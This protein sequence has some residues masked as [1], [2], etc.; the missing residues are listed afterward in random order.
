MSPSRFSTQKLSFKLIILVLLVSLLPLTAVS[1]INLLNIQ[2]KL[3]TAKRTELETLSQTLTQEVDAKL[4]SKK[5]FIESLARNPSTIRSTSDAN[6]HTESDLWASYDGSNYD[7]ETGMTNNKSLATWNAHNDIDP[8]YSIYLNDYCMTTGI[9]EILITDTRGFVFTNS[10]VIPSDFVQYEETWWT[11]CLQSQSGTYVDIGYFDDTNQVFLTIV[12]KV[13][14]FNGDF[15]GMVKARYNFGEITDYLHKILQGELISE[16]NGTTA[17][18]DCYSCHVQQDFNDNETTT[19]INQSAHISEDIDCTMCHGQ[20]SQ[21]GIGANITTS[22][23]NGPTMGSENVRVA[24]T[25]MSDGTILTY[26]DSSY[27]GTTISNILPTSSAGN[28]KAIESVNDNTFASD[29][30]R[31]TIK[32]ETSYL[33]NYYRLPNWNITLFVI[34]KATVIDTVIANE[35]IISSFILGVVIVISIVLAFLVSTSLVRPIRSIAEVTDNVAKG[36]LTGDVKKL[37]SERTDEIA[38]LGNSFVVMFENL[39]QFIFS[40]Q[41]SSEKVN[42]A[43]ED[44]ATT[45]E[46]I[47]ALSEE[48]AATI[49][50]VS[51]GASNQSDLANKGVTSLIEMDETIKMS[52]GD[53]ES[54]LSVIKDIASQ[55]NIL[56]LNAAIEAARAGEYGRGFAVVADNVRRLAEET[57]NNAVNI[58]DLTERIIENVGGRISNFREIFENFTAQAEEFSASSEEV[59]AATEEQT[60]AMNSLT[61]SAQEL[62]KLGEQMSQLVSQF[63]I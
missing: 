26:F 10:Q 22:Q 59:V 43:A 57:K 24:F 31:I 3:T 9:S 6:N 42:N 61:E 16:D 23:A 2:N 13:V 46:D 20:Q 36:N 37:Q 7:D 25:V 32:G 40:S 12:V 63:K 11:A 49:Q 28:R 48:I 39:H 51:R 34:E 14:D 5:I 33:A 50:Q 44:L 62:S 54:T 15:E 4:T 8:L 60:A 58:N 1:F 30:G 55:T 38:V 52:L 27:L 45:A 19:P 17:P 47:N 53:I 21:N 18:T 56:S 35:I 41:S 29:E